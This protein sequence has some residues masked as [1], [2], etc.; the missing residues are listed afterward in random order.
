MFSWCEWGISLCVKKLRNFMRVYVN[1]ESR[2]EI[3]KH[4]LHEA[5][6]A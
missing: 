6:L 2:F 4:S 1:R 3:W 5:S